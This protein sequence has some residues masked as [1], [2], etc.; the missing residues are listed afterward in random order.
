LFS[1]DG[2]GRWRAAII[3]A[4]LAVALYAAFAIWTDAGQFAAAAARIGAGGLAVLVALSLLNY[5]LR[6]ARWRIFLEALGHR[7]PWRAAARNYV[8]GFALTT[9]PG[10]AGE[11]IRSVGLKRAFGVPVV[12]SLAAFFAERFSDVM[13]L[14]L[15]AALAVAALPFGPALAAALASATALALWVAAS[16]A[17]TARF[18]VLFQRALPKR[19]AS[20][21]AALLA[22]AGRL[23]RGRALLAGFAL[24]LMAW[25]AEAWALYVIVAAMGAPIG[26]AAAMGIYAAALLGG[27]LFFL[28]GGLGGTEAIMFALLIHAGMDPAAAGAATVVSRITTL[29]LAVLIGAVVL[30]VDGTGSPPARG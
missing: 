22:Q 25:A 12:D 16:E 4:A 29:W 5:A 15:I 23:T 3:S 9:T 26:P 10:K 2:G 24:A 11:A 8:G 7:L 28:P 14:L 27:A 18:A 20:P 6:A 19:W 21:M 17:R 13:A 1:H 30:V